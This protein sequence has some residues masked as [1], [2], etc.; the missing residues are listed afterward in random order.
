MAGGERDQEPTKCTRVL[1]P[2]TRAWVR[3]S[4]QHFK[5][6]VYCFNQV[7]VAHSELATQKS[8]YSKVALALADREG[9][10]KWITPVQD[11]GLACGRALSMMA[12]NLRCAIYRQSRNTRWLPSSRILTRVWRLDSTHT[13]TKPVRATGGMTAFLWLS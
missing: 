4:P 8:L 10:R 3:A 9:R 5:T 12:S 1:R 2:P 13:L 6:L 11:V 7:F